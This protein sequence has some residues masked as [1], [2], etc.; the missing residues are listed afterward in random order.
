M[1]IPCQVFYWV[2]HKKYTFNQIEIV[3]T[4]KYSNDLNTG[5]LRSKNSTLQALSVQFP[6][7]LVTWLGE[8]FKYGHFRP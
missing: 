5:H 1:K 2:K 7:G 4:N 8:P 3:A 6:N